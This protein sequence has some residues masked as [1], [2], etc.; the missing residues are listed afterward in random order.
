MISDPYYINIC[1]ENTGYA[2]ISLEEIL[3]KMDSRMDKPMMGA[4]RN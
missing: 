2:P 3:R 1:V 4:A